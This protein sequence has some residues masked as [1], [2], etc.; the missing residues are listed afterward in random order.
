MGG[1][2]F[3]CLEVATLGKMTGDC[4]GSVESRFYR[5]VHSTIIELFCW[6]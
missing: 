4:N 6:G 5:A 3:L 1:C 2:S